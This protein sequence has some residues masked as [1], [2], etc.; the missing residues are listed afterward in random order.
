MERIQ[1]FMSGFC[2][3]ILYIGFK[4]Q[5]YT[6]GTVC[7]LFLGERLSFYAEIQI[8]FGKVQVQVQIMF[9]KVH[10]KIFKMLIK[11]VCLAL[12]IVELILFFPN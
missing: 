4:N 6:V 7:C 2:S 1:R 8:M 10:V 3:H 5:T 11:N 12:T 9:V